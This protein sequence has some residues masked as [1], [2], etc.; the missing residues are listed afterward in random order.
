VGRQQRERFAR[1]RVLAKYPPPP[2]P[3]PPEKDGLLL[4]GLADLRRHAD[5]GTRRAFLSMPEV[6]VLLEDAGCR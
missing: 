5:E 4:P 1:E 3:L 2:T 6:A